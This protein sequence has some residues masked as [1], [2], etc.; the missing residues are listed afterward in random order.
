MK[1]P[2]YPPSLS[3]EREKI[4]HGVFFY[5]VV[6]EEG[7]RVKKIDPKF[8]NPICICKYNYSYEIEFLDENIELE[9]NRI[10]T[11]ISNLNT[12]IDIAKEIESLENDVKNKINS[13]F[14]SDNPE[15]KSDLSRKKRE[16]EEQLADLIPFESEF[17]SVTINYNFYEFTY[18]EITESYEVASHLIRDSWGEYWESISPDK[19]DN[20]KDYDVSVDKIPAR[21]ILLKA[22][23]DDS[24]EILIDAVTNVV[25]IEAESYFFIV[26]LSL[27]PGSKWK[28]QYI[29]DI[30]VSYLSTCK[31][32]VV[33]NQSGDF[34]IK[35]TWVLK[36][37]TINYTLKNTFGEEVDVIFH[38]HDDDFNSAGEKIGKSQ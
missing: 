37:S 22:I 12:S 30:S 24:G 7:L 15:L 23:I 20:Y 32:M 33:I 29:N 26:E 38:I 4:E 8:Y 35:P 36:E 6:D 31:L 2:F 3:I 9:V 13:S 18:R 11:E 10:T 14:I 19:V 27:H 34:I 16:L 1:N 17:R 21:E 25:G 28:A 5:Y